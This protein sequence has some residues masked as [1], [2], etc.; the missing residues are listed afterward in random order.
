ATD[1]TYW[2]RH[3]SHTARFSDGLHRLWQLGNP[4][5]IE[6]GPGRTLSVLAAQHPDR[7]STLQ[8]GIWSMRQRYENDLDERV[9]LTAVGKVWLAGG[10]ISWEHIAPPGVRRRIP[11]PTYPHEKE[12]FWT[13]S[14]P[15]TA[16]PAPAADPSPSAT[17]ASPGEA[18]DDHP[19]TP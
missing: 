17:D 3:L 4:L 9:L 19:A 15:T 12:H 1:P 2:T 13:D 8:S 7:K 5:L 6:C 10:A 18:E 11:L 14:A 16:Q